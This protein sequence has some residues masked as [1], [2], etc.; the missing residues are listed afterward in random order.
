MPGSFLTSFLLNDHLLVDAGAGASALTA[1]QQAGLSGIVLS[2]VHLDHVGEIPFI[3]DNIF[4]ARDSALPIISLKSILDDL[5][6]YL[7]NNVIW[8]DFTVLA[9][10]GHPILKF[11]SV[12]EGEEHYVDGIRLTP[13]CVDHVVSAVG[14]AFTDETG[15][16][17]YTGDTGPT[18]N[19][20]KSARKLTDLRAIITEVSFPNQLQGVADAA[21]HFTPSSLGREIEKMPPDVP[22]Y[23]FHGKSRYQDELL[24]E[25]DALKEPRLRMCEQ[26]ETYEF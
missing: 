5:H 25:L 16:L 18:E 7:F 19:I 1:E 4:G 8:P 22:I 15:S 12:D 21:K 10:D 17:L 11:V 26:G 13:H 14:Y 2:H 6:K 24:D 9:V 23:L 3:A 20:W